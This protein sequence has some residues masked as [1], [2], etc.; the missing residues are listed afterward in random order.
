M[1][2]VD[3]TVLDGLASTLTTEEWSRALAELSSAADEWLCVL[4]R[5]GRL[6]FANTAFREAVGRP[7]AELLSVNLSDLLQPENERIR[8]LVADAVARSRVDGILRVQ[9][10]DTLRTY[11][12]VFSHVV[13]QSGKASYVLCAAKDLTD[14]L[15]AGDDLGVY[16][17]VLESI[18]DGVYVL[19]AGYRIKYANERAASHFGAK[20]D[21]I[22]RR[23]QDC[24]PGRIGSPSFRDVMQAMHEHTETTCIVE[25]P[26]PSWL[27]V[28]I[29]P[30]G[31]DLVVYFRD[32]TDAKNADD[33]RRRLAA[34]V[35]STTDAI[36]GKDMNGI[37]L[38]WNLGAALLYGYTAAEVIG[39]S[40]SLLLPDDM[41]D[42]LYG[43]MALLR[44]GE[45]VIGRR[46]RR[47]CKDG[48]IVDVSLTIAPIA[49]DEGVV[50]GASTIARDITPQMRH[51]AQLREAADFAIR[52]LDHLISLVAVLDP[53]GHVVEINRAALEAARLDRDQLVGARLDRLYCFLYDDGL[54]EKVRKAVEDVARGGVR[55]FDLRA[56]LVPGR[57]TD[58]DFSLAPMTDSAGKITHLIASGVDITDRKQAERELA[59]ALER[60]RHIA[61]TLQRSLLQ[62][63]PS[64]SF[65]GLE[66]ATMYEA[67][68]ADM[69]IG[70]DFV[71]AVSLPDHRVALIVGDV[72]GKGLAAA[73]RTAEIKYTLRAF[74]QE[75]CGAAAAIARL[76]TFLCEQ[77]AYDIDAQYGFVALSLAIVDPRTGLCEFA[78]AGTEPPVLATASGNIE[79]VQAEGMP[80]GVDPLATFTTACLTMGYGD[81]IMMVTDGLT[82]SRRGSSF[83]G[84]EGLCE[85]IRRV[86][87]HRSLRVA[88]DS[89]LE[90]SRLFSG[91]VLSDDACILLA[92]RK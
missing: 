63:P 26:G 51:E 19:D 59:S 65:A 55:R 54:C 89:C 61:A 53:A 34:I 84:I 48:R 16:R 39:K 50:V 88:A 85:V 28:H 76:N 52:V 43:I 92:R 29:F 30:A 40:I 35:E 15:A 47:R 82:E 49:D 45:K 90:A 5:D 91:G 78:R 72:S 58:I 9:P 87:S 46:T 68:S 56:E 75:N 27:D 21:I 4:D 37:I 8:Q 33:A 70:G 44:R 73:A 23:L 1:V 31:N 80:L 74:L 25:G 79:I 66:V 14:L 86:S 12:F 2:T 62:M 41:T 3:H 32:I 77:V 67:A 20:E 13:D 10:G 36:I 64:N 6:L 83:F 18:T 81:T 60:E 11:R 42:D 7:M 38:S 57:F 71:D 69:E 24:I 22:G 17:G